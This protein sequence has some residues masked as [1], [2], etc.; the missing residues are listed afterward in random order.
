M[1]RFKADTVSI[2]LL[3]SLIIGCAGI[4]L[5]KVELD[6]L[7]VLSRSAGY[8]LGYIVGG[9]SDKDLEGRVAEYY[10]QVRADGLTAGM[11]NI[12]LQYLSKTLEVNPGLLNEILYTLKAFGVQFD[13]EGLAIKV[14]DIP[15]EYLDNAAI[16]YRNGLLTAKWEREHG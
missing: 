4:T 11:L 2:I 14:Q 16:G 1:K 12:G 15:P 3:V 7:Q 10:M 8:F 13:G 5:T 6:R 9:K